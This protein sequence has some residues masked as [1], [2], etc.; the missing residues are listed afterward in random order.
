MEW[1][2]LVADV[3]LVGLLV[4]IWLGYQTHANDLKRRQDAASQR[5]QEHLEAVETTQKE[6]AE[7][8]GQL[9]ELEE[10]AKMLKAEVDS[11]SQRL[12]RMRRT[13]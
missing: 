13:D 12:A 8:E 10:Q 7:V 6:I 1:G 4:Y 11:A 9:P 2:I 5:I 3:A